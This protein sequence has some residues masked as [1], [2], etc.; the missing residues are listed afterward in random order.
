MQSAYF[1]FVDLGHIQQGQTILITA[2]TGG[3]GLGAIEMA[4][5]LGA[6]SIV[7]T[8][9]ASKKQALLDAGADHVIVTSDE[10]LVERVKSATSGKAPI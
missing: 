5:L 1:A 2:A 8:R 3:A 6:T 10:Y 4:R 9:S 7:T